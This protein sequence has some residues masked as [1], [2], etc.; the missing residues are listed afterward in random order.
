MDR[1][2]PKFII[3][4][5]SLRTMNSA[6]ASAESLKKQIA[7]TEEEL[8]NLREQLASIEAQDEVKRGLAGLDLGNVTETQNKD[9][10]KWPLSEEEYRRYGRQMIV[11]SVGIQGNS[12]FNIC[13]CAL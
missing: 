1:S 7:V 9:E 12:F 5:Q 4:T 2:A 6:T 13:I 10:K 3:T 11:P 8:K